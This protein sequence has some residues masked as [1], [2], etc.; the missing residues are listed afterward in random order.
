MD[1]TYVVEKLDNK[2]GNVRACYSAEGH[3][4][5]RHNFSTKDLT[6]AGLTALIEGWAVSA[7]RIWERA[8]T[9]PVIDPVDIGMDGV[10]SATYVPPEPEPEPEPDAQPNR[11]LDYTVD[12]NS[13]NPIDN[14]IE[15]TLGNGYVANF[16]MPQGS[17]KG[18]APKE[19]EVRALMDGLVEGLRPAHPDEA[20]H[21]RWLVSNDVVKSDIPEII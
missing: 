8:A 9:V 13:W 21:V 11:K 18:A 12:L 6:K 20:V 4:D 14:S 15:C 3:P 1:Y 16:T 2:N 19:K 5:L 10:K 17:Y 7:V